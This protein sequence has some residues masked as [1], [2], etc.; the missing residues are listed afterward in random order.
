MSDRD[1]LIRAY[2]SGRLL[3]AIWAALS[4]DPS[5]RKALG[6]DLAALHNEGVVDLIQAFC[7]LAPSTASGHDFFL[8]RHVFEEVLPELEAPV[9]ETAVCVQRLY[10]GA[11]TD[12]AAGTILD[13]FR[14]YCG[15]RAD[16]VQAAL[17]VI[18][19][20][21]DDLADLVVSVLVAGSKVDPST[22]ATETIRLATHPNLELRRRALFAIGRL[23]QWREAPASENA[24]AVIENAVRNE[25]DE[26]VH[27]CAIKSAFAEAVLDA[28]ME[29]RLTSAI[30]EAISKGGDAALHAASEVFGFRTSQLSQGLLA[31]L[32]E[33]LVQ[34]KVVN[35]RTLDNIDYG[36]AHL[37]QGGDRL[38]GLAFLEAILLANPE[39][40]E[41][42]AFND[43]VRTIRDTPSLRNWVATRW[44]L[45]GDQSLCEGLEA[46]LDSPLDHP[47][48]LEADT[49]L[50][51][52]VEP[53]QLFFAARKAIGYLFLRP[54]AA[55]SFLVSLLRKAPSDSRLQRELEKLL[56]NPLLINFSGIVAEYLA[57]RAGSE[58]EHVR[59]AIQ[60]PL[61]VL[62]SYL[63]G[64]KS[65]GDLPALHPSL[66]HRDTYRRHMAGEV[67]RS[68]KKAQAESVLFQ[69]VHRSVLLYGR[70][71][72]HHVFGPAGDIK[73]METHLGSHGVQIE[74][75]RLTVLDPQGLDYMLRVF[76]HERMSA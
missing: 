67:A 27:A 61:D 22:Y 5:E 66:E 57:S 9:P 53:R 76:R 55:T 42:S 52:E 68:F 59:S 43:S 23:D 71:A 63:A 34:V 60:R 75:P 62:E 65:V 69:L 8:L 7:G 18:E 17:A 32:L 73:R 25:D 40:L 12:L 15:R 21:P 29:P 6:S 44:L 2:Q 48:E 14:E 20:A 46:V 31:L 10:R 64:L 47:L 54:I 72:I 36:V 70:S 30:A 37:L 4:P 26:Q 16:R 3:D 11:G 58:E 28:E 41:L 49:E 39:D 51:G 56:F 35:G 38:R 50:L 1:S 24:V 19:A 33:R 74:V 13:A 45:R